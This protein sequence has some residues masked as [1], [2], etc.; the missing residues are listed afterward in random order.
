MQVFCRFCHRHRP[1]E[2]MTR[3][4]KRILHHRV[5][6]DRICD[7]CY[8]TRQK[9]KDPA[10]RAEIQENARREREASRRRWAVQLLEYK[11]KKESAE[12]GA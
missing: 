2:V 1:E 10:K 11:N 4:V 7:T 12:R 6:E 8:D 5:I 9:L 3:A